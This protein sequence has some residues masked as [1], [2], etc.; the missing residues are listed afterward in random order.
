TAEGEGRDLAIEYF[1]KNYKEGMEKEEAIILGLKA[2]IYATEK[3]LEKRAIE[4]GVVEEGKI[5]EILSAEQ[6]EK[7]FEEAK[8]E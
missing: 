5:F 8:G 7:Y 4:I 2:L 1:E 6:T 3:K